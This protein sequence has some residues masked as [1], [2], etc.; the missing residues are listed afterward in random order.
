MHFNANII[1]GNM[2]ESLDFGTQ[3][4]DN[5]SEDEL[6]GGV[7]A[8]TGSTVVSDAPYIYQVNASTDAKVRRYDDLAFGE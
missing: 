1:I 2:G 3:S 5:D 7:M 8:H 4:H 6:N